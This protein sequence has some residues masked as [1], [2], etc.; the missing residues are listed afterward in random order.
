MKVHL[1]HTLKE[2]THLPISALS[3]ASDG[4]RLYINALYF[5][6]IPSPPPQY[7]SKQQFFISDEQISAMLKE[8]PFDKATGK[9]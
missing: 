7:G 1:I 8:R 3:Q 9:R 2:W 4:E 6:R 5:Q